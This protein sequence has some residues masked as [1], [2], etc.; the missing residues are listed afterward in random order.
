MKTRLITGFFILAIFI[1]LVVVKD[2]FPLFQL[3]MALLAAYASFEMIQLFEHRHRFPIPAKIVIVIATVV[4]YMSFITEYK[5]STAVEGLKL[6]NFKVKVVPTLLI[7]VIILLGLMVLYADFNGASIGRAFTSIVYPA[8]GFSTLTV[9]R[10]SGIEFIIFLFLITMLTDTFAYVC[11]RLFGR[12]KMSP[13]ISPKKTWEGAIGG[14]LIACAVAIAFALLYDRTLSST[15]KDNFCIFDNG[16]ITKFK[17]YNKAVKVLFVVFITI[18]TSI[19]GQIGDLVASKFKRT[20]AVKDFSDIFPGHGGV[21]DRF[22]SA[23]Y[24][25]MFLWAVFEIFEKVIGA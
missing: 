17:D 23:I 10:A 11:G 6:F 19:M 3:F 16:V 7:I 8:F 20:Y 4:L 5:N 22:D 14:T 21:L 25:S 15:F 13:N 12:H 1:P 18:F 2:L 24:A 9:L